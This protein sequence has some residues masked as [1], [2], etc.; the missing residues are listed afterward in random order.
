MTPQAGLKQAPPGAD[1]EGFPSIV[2]PYRTH[3]T[4]GDCDPAGI[5]Y[6]P[7]Y[8]HWFDT[9]TW[10]LFA[11]VGLTVMGMIM[12]GYKMP[13]VASEIRFQ[14][15]AKPGDQCEVRSRIRRWG[16]KS[17][18][19]VHEVYRADDVLL[20]AGK[21]TRV[22]VHQLGASSPLTPQRVPEEIRERFRARA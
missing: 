11:S 16:N 3:V 13:L 22:W 21:E 1:E 19:V 9:A 15:A 17:F 7:T 4:W 12:D 6:Y 10:N 14:E 20:A 5:I 2:V 18:E 8:F